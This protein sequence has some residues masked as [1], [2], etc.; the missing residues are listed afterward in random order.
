MSVTFHAEP[1]ETTG[2][3]V[4]C[5]CEANQVTVEGGG[6]GKYS[7]AVAALTRLR[8]SLVECDCGSLDVFIT[9]ITDGDGPSLNVTA[10]NAHQ[11]L[12]A[13]FIASGAPGEVSGSFD[14]D[15]FLARFDVASPF[16]AADPDYVAGRL[17]ELRKVA[18]HAAGLGRKVVWG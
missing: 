2:F 9:P 5:I 14:A 8:G 16:A 18:E 17:P 6:P 7:E 3:V 1:G 11:L 4:G 10:S 12:A 13:L 15:A